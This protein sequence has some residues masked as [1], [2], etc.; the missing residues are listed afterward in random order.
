M[1]EA[2]NRRVRKVR[3]ILQSCC[4]TASDV[5]NPQEGRRRT[6]GEEL[7]AGLPGVGHW[8]ICLA[9]CLVLIAASGI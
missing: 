4:E 6:D 2:E 5:H 9:D 8:A 3:W 1:G 7:S